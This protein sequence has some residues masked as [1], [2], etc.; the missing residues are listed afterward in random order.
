VLSLLIERLR[1]L[2]TELRTGEL[3][4]GSA[5]NESYLNLLSAAV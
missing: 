1:R 4:L 2:G 3:V 5:V